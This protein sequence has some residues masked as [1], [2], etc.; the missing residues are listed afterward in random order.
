MSLNNQELDILK[1]LEKVNEDLQGKLMN[2]PKLM[3]SVTKPKTGFTDFRKLLDET[4]Q[5][6]RPIVEAFCESYVSS[7]NMLDSRVQQRL[8]VDSIALSEILWKKAVSDLALIQIMERIDS[9]DDDFKMFTALSSLL[10]SKNNL[11]KEL[12]QTVMVLEKNYKELK[13]E[14]FEQNKI[15]LENTEGVSSESL[16][17]RGTRNLLMAIKNVSDIEES[18]KIIEAEDE[19]KETTDEKIEIFRNTKYQEEIPEE[20]KENKGSEEQNSENTL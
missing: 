8:N 18:K 15:P 7:E 13:S 9:G 1:E 2:D 10:G 17:F 19:L 11:P 5:S 20:Q 6:V 12:L 3:Q 16:K 14:L 4:N